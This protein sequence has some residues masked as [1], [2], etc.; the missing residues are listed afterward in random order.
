MLSALACG[1]NTGVDFG[2]GSATGCKPITACGGNPAGAWQVA[3]ACEMTTALTN[4]DK[5]S[6][7]VIDANGVAS[8]MLGHPAMSVSRGQVTFATDGTYSAEVDFE[9]PTGATT[10]FP[11]FCL[12]GAGQAPLTCSAL[13]VGLVSALAEPTAAAQSYALKPAS[14]LPQFPDGLGPQ[15]AYGNLQCADAATGGC[16]CKYVIGDPVMD[17]G[18]FTI[19][20][21]I[22]SLSSMGATAPF[23]TDFC[24]A[25][26]SLQ[27]GAHRGGHR[28]GQG[29]LHTLELQMSP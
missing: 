17:R 11:A 16:D 15:P 19:D 12:A 8:V 22:I 18:T 20:A 25:T 21:G 26:G 7:L 9:T 10:S 6:Q 4:G 29:G 5:C 13:A 14:Q 24:A 2:A 27:L 1:P 23:V 28:L 3:A